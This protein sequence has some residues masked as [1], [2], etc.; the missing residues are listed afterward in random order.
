[1]DA[2]GR[3]AGVWRAEVEQAEADSGCTLET[4]LTGTASCGCWG[5]R[6]AEVVLDALVEHWWSGAGFA[7]WG[8]GLVAHWMMSLADKQRVLFRR[9]G[10]AAGFTRDLLQGLYLAHQS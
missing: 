5:G 8:R 1:M 9:G 7:I 2:M 6:A 10:H 4:W 3:Q